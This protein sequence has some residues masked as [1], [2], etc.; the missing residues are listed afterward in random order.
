MDVRQPGCRAVIGQ[1]GPRHP[2]VQRRPHRRCPA[3][4]YQASRQHRRPAHRHRAGHRIPRDVIVHR[5][6]RPIHHNA[7]HG[8]RCAHL[9]CL[10]RPASQEWS[11][12]RHLCHQLR[13]RE[14]QGGRDGG[15]TI[16][17]VCRRREGHRHDLRAAG[18]AD[19]GSHHPRSRPGFRRFPSRPGWRAGSRRIGRLRVDRDQR[20]CLTVS[21]AL[22]VF[23]LVFNTK[24]RRGPGHHRR[25][26]GGPFATCG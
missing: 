8:G 7:R 14:R 3:G 2:V 24:Y 21:D 5:R 13:D 12:D 9:P 4:R 26:P 25:Q 23:W 11:R 19:R 6:D 15:D 18:A 16:Q 17:P 22:P 20:H 1:P 10:Q